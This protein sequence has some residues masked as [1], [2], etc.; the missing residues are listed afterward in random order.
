MKIATTER[1][2]FT[3][4][5]NHRLW[6]VLC[7]LWW[8]HAWTILCV[9]HR[10]FVSNVVLKHTAWFIL[11]VNTFMLAVFWVFPYL[12][13][14]H[15]ARCCVTLPL[16]TAGELLLSAPNSTWNKRGFKVNVNKQSLRI[17]TAFLSLP[18]DFR[19]VCF[20]ILRYWS[21]GFGLGLHEMPFYIYLCSRSQ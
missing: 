2:A 20:M 15:L 13:P 10:I 18:S 4:S 19:H 7:F 8:E 9:C 6:G 16:R 1:K 17:D 5:P 14:L 11:K 3:A 21:L 12:N